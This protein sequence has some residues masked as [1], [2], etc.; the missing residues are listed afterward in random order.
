MLDGKSTCTAF[1]L[2]NSIILK[3]A[4]CLTPSF[5]EGLAFEAA[6]VKS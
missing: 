2:I 3:E 5:L 4:Y 6:D 1:L